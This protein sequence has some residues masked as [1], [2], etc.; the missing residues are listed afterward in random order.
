MVKS[1]DELKKAALGCE[2]AGG[3]PQVQV[4]YAGEPYP[5]GTVMFRCRV[6]KGMEIPENM[7][8]E[9]R[10]FYKPGPSC[11][12]SLR[13]SKPHAAGLKACEGQ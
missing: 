8:K 6:K 2:D 10:G 12:K 7:K 9:L 13:E 1:E 3:I 4:Q 5:D 11:L